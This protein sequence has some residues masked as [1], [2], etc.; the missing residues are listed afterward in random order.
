[1][2]GRNSRNLSLQKHR[3]QLPMRENKLGPQG[4]RGKAVN[5]LL[6]LLWAVI[7]LGRWGIRIAKGLAGR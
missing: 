5:F 7:W 6:N 1:N 2:S 4:I 3:R